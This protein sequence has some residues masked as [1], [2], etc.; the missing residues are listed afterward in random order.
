MHQNSLGRLLTEQDVRN[1]RPVRYTRKITVGR[2]LF[3]NVTPRGHRSWRYK[4]RFA[5]KYTQV[6]LG[7]YPETSLE[8]ARSRH[9]FARD[10][11]AQGTNPSALKATLGKHAFVLKMQE[12]ETARGGSE[13]YPDV[14]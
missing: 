5:G 4:Y 13:S 9:Q 7:T 6:V 3:L 10:L 2:A 1:V 8:C 11:L 14:A 12:W